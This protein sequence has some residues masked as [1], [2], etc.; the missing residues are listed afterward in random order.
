MKKSILP[1][2]A[3]TEGVVDINIQEL[4]YCRLNREHAIFLLGS[5]VYQTPNAKGERKFSK[6]ARDIP[7][8]LLYLHFF[9]ENKLLV[10]GREKNT[11]SYH[12]DVGWERYLEEYNFDSIVVR[13]IIKKEF[14]NFHKYL[15]NAFEFLKPNITR[16][17]PPF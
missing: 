13:A 17:S 4:T 8:F 6:F 3:M 11:Y 10:K 7:H 15:E 1:I 2:P 5:L 14:P 12:Y 16:T 9:L